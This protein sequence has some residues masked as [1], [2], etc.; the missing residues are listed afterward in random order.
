MLEINTIALKQLF[1]EEDLYLLE[2]EF[3]KP[4][5]PS[6]NVVE[7][8]EEKPK[9]EEVKPNYYQPKSKVII[10]LK[11]LNPADSELLGKILVAIKL[12]FHS[13][14]LIELDKIGEIDLSQIIAQKSVN[15]LI[16]FGIALPTVK[17]P[18][19]LNPYQF[20]EQQGI[21]LIYSDSL[22]NLQNDI[23]KKKA[24]WGA[25]KGFL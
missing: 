16:T 22:S 11:S 15:Q 8:V 24:L 13:I 2:N 3:S 4:E 23:P 5:K 9:I 1:A 18:I 10:L 19:S 12:D 25:L 20:T 17:L 6:E 7:V 14:D 21:K